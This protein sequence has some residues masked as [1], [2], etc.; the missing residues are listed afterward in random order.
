MQRKIIAVATF[1]SAGLF[2]G[3]ASAEFSRSYISVVGSTT[4]TPYAKAVGE[5]VAKSKKIQTPLLQATGTSGGI[6]LFCEG[7]GVT[8]PDVVVTSRTMKSKEQK[9]CRTNGV[10]DI[11][12]L[13]IG[14]DGLVLA[15]SK[16]APPMDLTRQQAR[17]ML[18]KWIAD[19]SGNPVLNPN[20]TW[21]DI[22]PSL[23]A[24]KIEILGPP[25]SSGTY[26]AFA[27]LIS[28]FTCKGA[29]WV[30]PGK[31][32]PTVDM[33]KKCRSIR[34]D[35][36]YI[37]GREND[38]GSV[39]QVAASPSKVAILDYQLI[40]KNAG[41][42]RAVPIDGVD[43]TPENI[44]AKAYPASRPLMVYVK[45]EKI[46]AIPGLRDFIGEF[47]SES[48]WGDRGYLTTLGLIP[49]LPDERA[50][51]LSEVKGLGISP[52]S[53][54][55]GSKKASSKGKSHHGSKAKKK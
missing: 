11:L 46:G 51:Y 20:K 37:R 47:A 23:P 44:A 54:T 32:E 5:R 22:N 38:E 45:K 16:N 39:A 52:S 50:T 34:E 1:L 8:S 14:Y 48:A 26:D 27:D 53:G 25:V 33:L 30:A 21:K 9:E 35:R 19:D 49:M 4:A 3:S 12:E 28:D 55:Q 42:L 40:A 41:K 24:S 15:Q 2:A 18:A 7:L 10:G 29:P 43:P 6:K 36:A 31:T 13:K 17:L